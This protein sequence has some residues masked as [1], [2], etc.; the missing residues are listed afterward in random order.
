MGTHKVVSLVACSPRERLGVA[1]KSVI[2][3][4]V[5][6]TLL[7]VCG[8]VFVL[9]QWRDLTSRISKLEEYERPS[10][11]DMVT[12]HLTKLLSELKEDT[13]EEGSDQVYRNKRSQGH[14]HPDNYIR[15]E[16]EDMLMMMTYSM[17]PVRIMLDLC[18]STRG[19]CLTGP[20]GPQ[21]PSGLDGLPGYNGSDGFPGLP[22]KKGEPGVKGKKGEIGEPGSKGEKGD[23]GEI[24]LPGNDGME[25]KKG[26]KGE[27]GE[28]GDT[29]NDI[30]AEGVKGDMGPPGPPGLP[31]PPGP[32]GPPGRRKAK[33]KSKITGQEFNS[34]CTGE[35]CAVPNDD[36]MVGK[37]NETSNGQ[38]P[39]PG[40]CIIKSIESPAKVVKVKDTYGAWMM[41]TSNRTDDRIWIAGH[42][43]GLIVKQY[44][45][46]TDLLDDNYKPIKL[47][48]FYH[49]CG[50]LVNNK[51]LYYHKGGSDTIVRYELESES[52]QTLSIKNAA[53]HN[54]SYLFTNSKTYFQIAADE[55]DLWIIYSSDIDNTI[56]VA[57][58]D[59]KHFSITQHIN[60][61][62]PKSK[63]GNAFIAC[64][65]LYVTDTK[66]LRVT[67]ALNLFKG[68]QVEASFEL[69]SSTSV[70]SMLSYNPKD[71]R[72]YTWEDGNLLLYPVHFASLT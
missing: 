4:L 56:M 16:N 42:F 30:L 41:E 10:Q 43:S 49:G 8:T 52:F 26:E 59:E 33:E 37:S 39:K 67:F 22:G 24:G 40:D 68:K 17:V 71:Q 48:W 7:N 61:T 32:E 70:L 54:R 20:P 34:K 35:S 72:L 28:N 31:G 21:G 5:L 51:Y 53:F 13:S 15:A 3:V 57:H 23:P 18:N 27:K 46:L 47:R 2:G 29:S 63:A 65:I 44:E 50:H 19:I 58:L 66:D 64:G 60:T 12:S 6:L 45:N 25:G 1:F 69:R 36:T 38:S 14:K 11:E 55:K 9:L 62:Y